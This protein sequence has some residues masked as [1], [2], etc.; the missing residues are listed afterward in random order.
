[1]ASKIRETC[2]MI[3]ETP[4]SIGHRR[5]ELGRDIR[6]FPVPPHIIFFRLAEDRAEIL[7][8]IHGRRELRPDM[9]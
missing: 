6:S 9:F 8:I 7:R 5:A 4:G 1:M 3:A 2:K